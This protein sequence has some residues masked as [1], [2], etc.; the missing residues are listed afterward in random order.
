[1]GSPRHS[2]VKGYTHVFDI[3]YKCDGPAVQ[4]EV[5]LYSFESF[6]E[7]DG[8][9]IILINFY[10]SVLTPFLHCFECALQFSEHIVS[11]RSVA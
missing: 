6:G 1:M 3:I 2:P 4:I 11:L 5:S 8:S 7:V 9:S 10:V